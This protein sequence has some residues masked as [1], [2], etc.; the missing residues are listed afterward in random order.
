M[1]AKI[2]YQEMSVAELELACGE[3]CREL[4]KLRNEKAAGGQLEKPHRISE[5][6]R[7]VARVLRLLGSKG[8]GATG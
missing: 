7:N 1:S 3:L 5:V 8:K 4:F 6:R 2:T